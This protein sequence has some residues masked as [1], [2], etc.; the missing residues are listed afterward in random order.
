MYYSPICLASK[1]VIFAYLNSKIWP[2]DENGNV[3]VRD[4]GEKVKSLLSLAANEP[5]EL[6]NNFGIREFVA[7]QSWAYKFVT[8]HGLRFR[9]AHYEH[10]GAV[11]TRMIDIYLSELAG[12]I[13]QYG[14]DKVINMDETFV[15]NRNIPSKI[16]A[17]KGQ[18]DVKT[19]QEGKINLKEGTTYICTASMNPSIRLPFAIVAKGKTKVTERKYITAEPNSDILLHSKSGWTTGEVMI[20]YLNWLSKEVMKNEEFALVLDVYSSHREESVKLE[21]ARLKI[22]LIYVPACGTGTFQP[23]D[24]KIFGPLKQMLKK[25]DRLN[26]IPDDKT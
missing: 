22:K 7:S 16:L 11:K 25:N 15:R 24:R 19:L 2:F 17:R 1:A 10:R 3:D 23:L 5:H 12:A 4:Y 26:K 9:K 18:S 21:A 14:P 20:K 13:A 6:M 8:D